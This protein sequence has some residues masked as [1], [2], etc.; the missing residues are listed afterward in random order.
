MKKVILC[1]NLYKDKEFR[2]TREA[3]QLLEE[4]GFAVKISPEYMDEMPD[5]LP[6]DLPICEL[7]DVI[8]GASLVVSLGGDGTIMHTARRMI[9]HQIP[10][11]GINLGTVGFLAELE[12]ADLDRMVSAAQGNYQLS[13]RMMLDVS[14]RRRGEIVYS[15]FALNDVAM[16]GVGQII[17]MTA[18]G[19]GRK[20]LEYSGDGIVVASPT[21]STAYSLS[22]GGPLVEPTAEN[23]I[24][25]PICAHALIARSFV[26][27]PDRVVTVK[28]SDLRSKAFISVDGGSFEVEDEDVLIVRKADH[29]TF[30]ANVGTKAFYDIVFEKLGD[31]K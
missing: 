24:L 27:A 2:V 17:R 16:H 8:D 31:A 14:L 15:N 21:G 12:Y 3:K 23:I 10:I 22:A 11:L 4:A 28:V 18:C 20:I 29:R 13:P 5:A 6:A 19:D 7:A 26:L 1:P 30:I 25:T 9:G